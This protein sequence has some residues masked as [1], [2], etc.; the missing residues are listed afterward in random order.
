MGDKNIAEEPTVP[1]NQPLDFQQVWRMFQ[2]TDKKFQETDRKFQET[3]KLFKE[4]DRKIRKLD[5]LFTSQWGKLVES[6]VEGDLIKLLTERD[7]KVESIIPRRRGNKD[8]LNYEFDLI[9]INGSEM[10]I[11][12]VKTTL[13]PQDIDDFHEK[14]WKAKTFMPEYKDWIIYGAV[15]FI[16]ADGSSDRMA[17]NQG[18]FVIRATGNSSSIVN[19]PDFQPKAF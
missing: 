16:T 18:F 2:E 17:Q 10:V 4:T 1:Y 8:G 14:L 9:A 6:L 11:V 19:E 13:R 5:R 3:E 7:I 15:A 12:E